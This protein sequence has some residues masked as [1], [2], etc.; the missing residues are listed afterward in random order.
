[1]TL[2]RNEFDSIIKEIE[3]GTADV[4]TAER[5]LKMTNRLFECPVCHDLT[6]NLYGKWQACF[7]CQRMIADKLREEDD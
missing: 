5:L 4:H 1:M 6:D 3:S 2:N 7:D